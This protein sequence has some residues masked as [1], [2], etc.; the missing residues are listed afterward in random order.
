MLLLLT[1]LAP[2]ATM[3]AGEEEDVEE[4]V[5]PSTISFFFSSSE[6]DLTA[7]NGFLTRR[8]SLLTL[9]RAPSIFGE[10]RSKGEGEGG[11]EKE[12]SDKALSSFSLESL[13]LF[14]CPSGVWSDLKASGIFSPS[15]TPLPP[16]LITNGN[17]F[18]YTKLCAAY[19]D[20]IFVLSLW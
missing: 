19:H 20:V 11:K 13:T 8:T 12:G 1:P 6:E 18:A 9:R 10:V 16:F 5:E 17:E 2:A 3:A 14:A 7:S 4:N 15:L